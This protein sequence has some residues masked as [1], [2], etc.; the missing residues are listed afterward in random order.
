MV[1]TERGSV[2]SACHRVFHVRATQG[3][4]GEFRRDSSSHGSGLDQQAGQMLVVRIGQIH[5]A[6]FFRFASLSALG[7]AEVYLVCLNLFSSGK[8][9]RDFINLLRETF[10][11]RRMLQ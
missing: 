9:M 4:Q 7:A 1:K 10:L 5:G 8:D 2:A 6:I 3:L 11:Q